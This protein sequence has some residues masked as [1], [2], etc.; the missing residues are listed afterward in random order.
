SVYAP[1]YT[2]TCHGAALPDGPHTL[3]AYAVDA[4]GNLGYLQ[5]QPLT[6]TVEHTPPTGTFSITGSSGPITFAG[7]AT[8]ASGIQ[9][10]TFY[11]DGVFVASDYSSP[12][13]IAFDSTGLGNGSH[14]LLVYAMDNMGNLGYLTRGRAFTVNNATSDTTPPAVSKLS[15]AGTA[16]VV[17]LGAYAKDDH[18]VMKA[19]FYVDGGL[20]GTDTS[21]FSPSG[22]SVPWASI[23]GNH[24]LVVKATDGAGNVTTSASYPFTTN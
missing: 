8:D 4:A 5:P 13:S 15:V 21:Y 16:G 14:V 23:P 3:A 20:V 2:T 18:L 1:P 7:T 17:I 6:F 24:T 19:D 9:R 10:I 11:V 12:Y 22:Y